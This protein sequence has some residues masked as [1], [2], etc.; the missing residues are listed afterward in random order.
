MR[1]P[2]KPGRRHANARQRRE[3]A[4]MV[5]FL[6]QGGHQ[7]KRRKPVS[8]EEYDSLLRLAAKDERAKDRKG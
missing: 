8:L 3:A 5:E 1:T 6:A 4:R 7:K 2:D